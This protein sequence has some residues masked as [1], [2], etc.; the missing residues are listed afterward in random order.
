[1][2]EKAIIKTE[3]IT[4]IKHTGI[5]GAGNKVRYYTIIWNYTQ[6]WNKAYTLEEAC[7]F[8]KSL[9]LSPPRSGGLFFVLYSKTPEIRLYCIFALSNII[10]YL[11]DKTRLQLKSRNNSGIIKLNTKQKSSGKPSGEFC[12][13]K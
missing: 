10:S 1:M 6:E 12:P 11:T 2:N 8:A 13:Q 4:V 9:L 7:N 5:N 3:H